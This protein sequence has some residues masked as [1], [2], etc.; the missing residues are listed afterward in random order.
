MQRMKAIVECQE[1]VAQGVRSFALRPASDSAEFE[2]AAAGSH[3]DLFLAQ[4][5]VRSYS[6]YLPAAKGDPYRIAV[7]LDPRSRGGSRHMFAHVKVGDEIDISL[8]KNHFPL[9]ED[10]SNTVM[11]AGGI[12]VTPL[13]AM[14]TRLTRLGKPWTLHYAAQAR[15]SAA[16]INELQELAY[17]SGSSVHFSFGDD[18]D[19]QRID[20]PKVFACAPLDTHFYCCGPKRMIDAFVAAGEQ[21]PSRFVHVEHFG[22]VTPTGSD[23]SFTVRLARSGKVLTVPAGRTILE[24]VEQAGISVAH[25]C[26]EGV[27]AACET[28]VIDGIPDHRDLVLSKKERGQNQS[29]MICCSGSV[30]AEL[31]LDL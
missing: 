20:L 21:R 29:M 1:D 3:V 24:V 26:K 11:V 25:A 9:T 30:T 4:D 15:T 16:F 18:P 12:G 13:M 10:A 8:P 6:L 28:R 31:V 23:Q 19:R 5:L 2:V 27:C 14:A 7:A 22:G 17:A